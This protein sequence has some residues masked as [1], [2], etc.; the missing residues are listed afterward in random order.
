MN[1]WLLLA[2][3]LMAAPAFAD[4]PHSTL[5]IGSS[6]PDFSLP[7]TDGKTHKLSDFEKSKVLVIVF[8]CKRH[9]AR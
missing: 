6:A 7:G 4:E 3:V 5:A 2:L 1:M 9:S 8:T